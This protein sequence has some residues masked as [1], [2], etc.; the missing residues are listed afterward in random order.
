MRSMRETSALAGPAKQGIDGSFVH[1]KINLHARR[2][3]PKKIARF[4]R[5]PV[6]WK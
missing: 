6:Q 2:E 3:P 5:A 1:D 4:D